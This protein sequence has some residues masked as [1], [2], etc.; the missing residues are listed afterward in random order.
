MVFSS[1]VKNE[2]RAK[3]HDLKANDK[4]VDQTSK[5]EAQ[6]Q[7][8]VGIMIH[9]KWVLAISIVRAISNRIGTF[10]LSM[11]RKLLGMMLTKTRSGN[12]FRKS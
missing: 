3:V 9:D 1:S 6:E 4:R 8:G 2:A 12:L 11:H 10:S 5:N 7:L